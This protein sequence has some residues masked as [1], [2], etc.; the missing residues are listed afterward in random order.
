M[1]RR[2]LA[3]NEKSKNIADINKLVFLATTNLN[4]EKT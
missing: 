1:F 3:G 2:L 4:F